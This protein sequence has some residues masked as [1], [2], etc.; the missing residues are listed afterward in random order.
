MMSVTMTKIHEMVDVNT[1][2]GQ[3]VSTPDG[4]TIIP[5]SKVSFGFGAGGTDY[6]GKYDKSEGDKN[7]GGGS[8]AGVN[9]RPVSFLV[10]SP[11]GVKLLPVTPPP[12][13]AVDRVIEAV[14]AL[15]EK[16][17]SLFGRKKEKEDD[18]EEK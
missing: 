8:G 7:F 9:I 3:P 13:S 11:A 18:E 5:V 4:T 15:L 6:M 10:V 17:V 1:I 12:D 2:V 14:P 16:V